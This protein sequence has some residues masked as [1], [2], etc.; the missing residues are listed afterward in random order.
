MKSEEPAQV[1]TVIHFP[2][3]EVWKVL[4]DPEAIANYMLGARLITDWKEGSAITWS[5]GSDDR[6]I[7]H[8]GRV[9]VVREPELL[10]YSLT[11]TSDGVE[12]VVSIELQE[13][14][15]ITHLR[16]T[17]VGNTTEAAR[18]AAESNWT[19]MLDNVK[20]LMGEA[21]VPSP[22]EPRV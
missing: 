22:E 13:V 18:E 5:S 20:K 6:S 9:M 7:T 4:L 21:P 2:L 19:M 12:K 15:G 1:T 3:E 11:N 17:Q 16:V 10:R 8:Q 14:A